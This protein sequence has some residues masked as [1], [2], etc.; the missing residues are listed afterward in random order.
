MKRSN[1][2]GAMWSNLRIWVT[3]LA[4]VFW[5]Y[6]SFFNCVFLQPKSKELQEPSLDVMKA[7][8]AISLDSRVRYFLIFDKCL[9]LL[10]DDLQMSERW[11]RFRWSYVWFLFSGLYR[12]RTSIRTIFFYINAGAIEWSR[13]K[14]STCYSADSVS[15]TH[16]ILASNFVFLIFGC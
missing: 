14:I 12:W 4:A 13:L 11:L 16:I 6:W 8:T 9:S 3:I 2:T 15:R 10:N 5:T 7:C 1:K